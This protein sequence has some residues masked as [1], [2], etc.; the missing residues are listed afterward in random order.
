MEPPAEISNHHASSAENARFA[1]FAALLEREGFSPTTRAC[2]ASDWWTISEYAHR[3]TGRRFRLGV[4]GPDGFQVQRAELAA[5][6]TSVATLNRRLSFLRRYSAFAAAREPALRDVAEGFAAVP[7]QPLEKR[8]TK[9][10]THGEEQRL[11]AAADALGPTD[12]AIVALLLGAGLRASELAALKRADVVGPHAAPTALRVRGSRAKTV[13]LGP[14]AQSR[15]GG[16]LASERGRPAEPLFRGRSGAALGEDGIGAAVERAARDAGLEA[17]PRT[18]R[19]TFGVRYVSE[20]RDDLAG[21]ASALGHSSLAAARAYR[22]EAEAGAPVVS[23]QRW[24]TIDE[25]SPAEGI[26]RR[27]FLGARIAVAR[28]LLAPQTVVKPH[29]HRAERVTLVLSG[30]VGF[31]FGRTRVEAA[32]GEFVHVPSGTLHGF[33]VEGEGPALLLHV[34]ARSQRPKSG[35]GR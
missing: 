6:G 7:F 5:R 16:L 20:H 22:S 10:L 12:A 18:L 11:R 28:E 17:T 32:A 14:V 23:V 2:Y 21:L 34:S 25:E 26:R 29:V 1:A 15:I 19:H 8:T 27:S 30:R 9:A 3:A 35:E 33:T 24:S 31:Q 4:F 13:L